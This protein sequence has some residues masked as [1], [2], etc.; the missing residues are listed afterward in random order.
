MVD[1]S[2]DQM[3]EVLLETIVELKKQKKSTLEIEN[4]IE[5]K[6]SQIY[7]LSE[8]EIRLIELSESAEDV[9]IPAIMDRSEAVSS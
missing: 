3:F 1:E 9:A 6:L 5:L 4:Q 2:T 8:D 7:S